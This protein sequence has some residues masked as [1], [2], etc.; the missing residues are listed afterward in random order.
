MADNSKRYPVIHENLWDISAIH[1]L[2][3]CSS[4]AD[5]LLDDK[6][7]LEAGDLSAFRQ[8]HAYSYKQERNDAQSKNLNQD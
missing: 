5:I 8:E 4:I 1:Q 2:K 3:N 6:Q 7:S